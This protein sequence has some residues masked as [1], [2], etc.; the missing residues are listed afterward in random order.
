VQSPGAADQ[1]VR[2]GAEWYAAEAV[3][4]ASAPAGRPPGHPVPDAVAAGAG[5]REK[6]PE[7]SLFP[8]KFEFT[9]KRSQLVIKADQAVSYP[10]DLCRQGY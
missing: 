6:E 3:V 5:S 1:P 9:E 2:T 10:V 8:G 7:V 4:T